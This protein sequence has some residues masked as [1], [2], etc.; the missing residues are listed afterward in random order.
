M[1]DAIQTF[2]DFDPGDVRGRIQ[3]ENVKVK[4]QRTAAARQGW[5]LDESNSSHRES[6]ASRQP[7]AESTRVKLFGLNDSPSVDGKTKSPLTKPR[8]DV[9]R[10]LIQSGSEGLTKDGLASEHGGAVNMLKALAR[11][12]R[13]WK[14]V[15]KLPGKPGRRYRI[16]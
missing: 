5:T 6:S 10:L 13:D 2:P 8:Y 9:V 16:E 4:E 11:S 12:D 1:V 15:I 3:W 14:K 7:V